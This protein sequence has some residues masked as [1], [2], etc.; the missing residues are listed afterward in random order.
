MQYDYDM[1]ETL[2]SVIEI[3]ALIAILIGLISIFRNK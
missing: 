3:V 1:K 2:E